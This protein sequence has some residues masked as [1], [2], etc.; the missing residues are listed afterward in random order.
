VACAGFRPISVCPPVLSYVKRVVYFCFEL[1]SVFFPNPSLSLSLPSPSACSCGA[2]HIALTDECVA[3]FP[4][5]SVC[6]SVCLSICLSVYLSVCLLV[7]FVSSFP[8]ARFCPELQGPSDESQ[9]VYFDSFLR[10]RKPIANT[11]RPLIRHPPAPTGLKGCAGLFVW[12]P[13]AVFWSGAR[14][15]LLVS[16]SCRPAQLSEDRISTAYPRRLLTRQT[17]F[18]SRLASSRAC[19]FAVQ[20]G[21]KNDQTEAASKQAI[22]ASRCASARA[23]RNHVHICGNLVAAFVSLYA[24]HD[25]ELSFFVALFP[26][27]P[28]LA[29][30]HARPCRRLALALYLVVQRRLVLSAKH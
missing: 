11:S 7:S 26:G 5:L 27:F 16:L 17:C 20:N 23:F 24:V 22:L 1:L 10:S 29:H 3:L 18:R 15:S 9:L 28:P 4:C 6:L 14:V 12:H 25:E 21:A 8:N 30:A 13:G 2:Y 19:L